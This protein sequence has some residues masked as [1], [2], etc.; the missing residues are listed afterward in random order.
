MNQTGF[1]PPKNHASI[2][3][4]ACKIITFRALVCSKISLETTKM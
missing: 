3:D 2:A 4:F 1:M